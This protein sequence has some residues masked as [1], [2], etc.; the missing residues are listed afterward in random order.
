MPPASLRLSSCCPRSPELQFGPEFSGGA[1]AVW[2]LVVFLC[3]WSRRVWCVVCAVWC[4]VQRGVTCCM[5]RA[6]ACQYDDAAGFSRLQVVLL[7]MPYFVVQTLRS[8]SMIKLPCRLPLAA[9]A[10]EEDGGCSSALRRH[11]CTQARAQLRVLFDS[12]VECPARYGRTGGQRG[13]A[14]LV[15][16]TRERKCR[17]V[18]CV[19]LVVHGSGPPLAFRPCLSCHP[20]GAGQSCWAGAGRDC[21]QQQATALG[22]LAGAQGG[23]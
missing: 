16:C 5:L 15:V 6:A 20:T 7:R 10:A 3:G 12:I 8:W 13:R 2:L 19:Q 9:Q 1:A 4:G 14:E 18:R 17:R 21:C 22:C 23:H 11:L